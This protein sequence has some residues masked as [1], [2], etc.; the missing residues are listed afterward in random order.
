MDDTP[1]TPIHT[2]EYMRIA[3]PS[4]F[5]ASRLLYTQS[6]GRLLLGSLNLWLC[7]LVFHFS[8]TSDAC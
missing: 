1:S 6:Q 5:Y 2:A 3:R 8:L 4:I 7:S